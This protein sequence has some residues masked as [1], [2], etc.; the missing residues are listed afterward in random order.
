MRI[1]KSTDKR[2]GSA[3]SKACEISCGHAVIPGTVHEFLQ[4]PASQGLNNGSLFVYK[5]KRVAEMA[6]S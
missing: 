1:L 2:A 6:T 5:A 4:N 3:P